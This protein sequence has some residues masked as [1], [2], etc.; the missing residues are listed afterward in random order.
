MLRALQGRRHIPVVYCFWGGNRPIT[1]PWPR[2]T[3]VHFKLEKYTMKSLTR[4]AILAGVLA[5]SLGCQS[6]AIVGLT[7]NDEA[8]LRQVLRPHAPAVEGREAIQK[9]L[10]TLPSISNAKG[11]GV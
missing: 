6:R 9:W 8:S 5:A 1:V 7:A 4:L 2:T 10:A 3:A 11:Q